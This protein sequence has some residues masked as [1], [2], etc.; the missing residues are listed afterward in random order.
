MAAGKSDAPRG[1]RSTKQA[2]A[3]RP[4]YSP[5]GGGRQTLRSFAHFYLLAQATTLLL[6]LGLRRKEREK[7]AKTNT[8]VEMQRTVQKKLREAGCDEAG[9]GP[10]AGPVVGAAVILP[11]RFRNKWIND[12]KKLTHKQ[13]LELRPLIEEKAIAWGVGV[14][15]HVEI[16]EIN[17]LN[18]S[19]LA[20][21]RSL[22]LLSIKPGFI[23]MD[24]NRFR[25]YCDTPHEC[26]IKGDGKIMN[27]AAASIL[28]KTYRDEMMLKLHEKY[29]MYH[30]DKNKGYPTKQHREAIREFGSCEFHR[31]SFQLLPAKQLELFEEDSAQF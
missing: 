27:I 29:P 17:I 31:K 11:P 18:A 16:D 13:L 26:V 15:S 23:A 22:D 4:L 30:W 6:S 25:T 7:N 14:A 5:I 24:G 12:S 19:Y 20:I 10:L 8:F 2:K 3:W 21:H 28:A 1:V 9:R